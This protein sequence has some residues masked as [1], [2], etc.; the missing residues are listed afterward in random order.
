MQNGAA[1][2]ENSLAVSYKTKHTITLLGSYP[3]ELKNYVHKNLY[4]DVY[5][6]FIHNCPNWKQ[7]RSPSVGEWINSGIYRQYYSV[8]ERNQ[9]PSHEKKRKNLKCILLT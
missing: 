1:T 9:L 6:S 2:L 4:T 8:L 5:S 7:P 3:S